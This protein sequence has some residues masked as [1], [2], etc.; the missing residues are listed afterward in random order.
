MMYTSN[1]TYLNAPDMVSGLSGHSVLG[2]CSGQ[3]YASVVHIDELT[4][5]LH[6]TAFKYVPAATPQSFL[7]TLRS[8]ENQSL[9]D[10]LVLDGDGEWIREGLLTGSLCIVSDE[11]YQKDV[12]THISLAGV[13]IYCMHKRLYAKVSVAEWSEAASNYRDKILGGLLILL[14]LRAATIQR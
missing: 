13:Q 2:H 5:S 14:L 10:H 1:N 7:E 8:F 6:P 12:S 9:W 11:T 3:K 4:V